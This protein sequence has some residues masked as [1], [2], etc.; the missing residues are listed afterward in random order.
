MN[1]DVLII[2]PAAG[3]GTRM[4][5]SPGQ[6]KEML[7]DSTGK[8][9]INYSLHI[10]EDL[11]I[12]PLVITRKDKDQLI[13]HL[14]GLMTRILI[15]E[16]EGEWPNTIL[17]SKHLW[18]KRNILILPDTRFI[19]ISVIQPM[20]DSLQKHAV[21]AAIHDVGDVSLWGAVK[22]TKTGL[23][24]C[25]KPHKKSKGQAWGLLGWRLEEGEALFQHFSTRNVWKIFENSVSF[26]LDEFKDITRK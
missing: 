9:I 1:E 2:I 25:E 23:K 15:I 12:N 20:I 16:P 4:L 26:K 7:P 5:M 21:S 6:A 14:Q 8:P 13:N 11:H 19:P 24:M 22:K 3:Y 18:K 17:K 10:A